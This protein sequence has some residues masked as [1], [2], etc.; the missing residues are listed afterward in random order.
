M[1]KDVFWLTIFFLFFG[2]GKPTPLLAKDTEVFAS[3]PYPPNIM[4][5]LDNSISMGNVSGYSVFDLDK[6][7]RANEANRYP[8]NH[9]NYLHKAGVGF[10]MIAA[11][12]AYENCKLKKTPDECQKTNMPGIPYY[13]GPSE[14]AHSTEPVPGSDP[15]N[16]IQWYNPDNPRFS[17]N[18]YGNPPVVAHYS[19]GI[20][21]PFDDNPIHYPDMDGDGDKDDDDLAFFPYYDNPNDFMLKGAGIGPYADKLLELVALQNQL[22]AEGR[23]AEYIAEKTKEWLEAIQL[24]GSYNEIAGLF[25]FSI[26]RAFGV[27][28][29]SKEACQLDLARDPLGTFTYGVMGMILNWFI[30][31]SPSE[32]E[33]ITFANP[34]PINHPVP[35]F[36]PPAHQ[37]NGTTNN[38]NNGGGTFPEGEGRFDRD[39]DCSYARGPI[40]SFV[41]PNP[42][43]HSPI[44]DQLTAFFVPDPTAP[45]KLEDVKDAIGTFFGTQGV[46][47][48][49]WGLMSYNNISYRY[50]QSDVT[51]SCDLLDGCLCGGGSLHSKY[52]PEGDPS[53]NSPVLDFYSSFRPAFSGLP[54]C[55][56][57]RGGESAVG[58]KILQKIDD[59][60]IA[61]IQAELDLIRPNVRGTPLA[62]TLLTAYLYFNETL[63]MKDE[64]VDLPSPPPGYPS[65]WYDGWWSPTNP[66]GDGGTVG[67]QKGGCPDGAD[68][69]SGAPN[70]CYDFCNGGCDENG[71]CINEP[72]G[73]ICDSCQRNYIILLTDGMPDRDGDGMQS[74]YQEL[75]VSWGERE[76]MNDFDWLLPGPC[77]Q[78]DGNNLEDC[79]LTNESDLVDEGFD[80]MFY[81]DFGTSDGDSDRCIG[82]LNPE[83]GVEG[84]LSVFHPDL[85]LQVKLDGGFNHAA[86]EICDHREFD[87]SYPIQV[88]LYGSSLLDDFAKFINEEDVLPDIE[89]ESETKGTQHIKTYTIGFDFLNKPYT[90]KNGL[91]SSYSA[92]GWYYPEWDEAWQLL[93]SA[94]EKGGTTEAYQ[95]TDNED[96]LDVMAAI[97][98]EILGTFSLSAPLVHT[99]RSSEAT[100]AEVTYIASF[101]RGAYLNV[102]QVL[103]ENPPMDP[104]HLQAWCTDYQGMIRVLSPDNATIEGCR[105]EIQRKPNCDYDDPC[106]ALTKVKTVGSSINPI[107]VS[108]TYVLEPSGYLWDAAEE[109]K[110]DKKSPDSR[111]IYTSKPDDYGNL[112]LLEFNYFNI[113]REDVGCWQRNNWWRQWQCPPDWTGW[114]IW[115]HVEASK[116][117]KNKL[118][119]YVR[120]NFYDGKGINFPDWT[121]VD[122]VEYPERPGKERLGSIIHSNMVHVGAPSRLYKEEG[123]NYA[124]EGDN[125]T[126]YF[127]FQYGL[128][129]PT[130]GENTRNRI[131]VVGANDGML[132]GFLAGKWE[133]DDTDKAWKY[134]AGTGEEIW[135][136]IPNTI[137]KKLPEIW[138]SGG[139]FV[140]GPISVVD[141]WADGYNHRTGTFS[142]GRDNK[143]QW[144]EWATVL[145]A[146]LG[147]NGNNS[148]YYAYVALDITQGDD[149][150]NPNIHALWEFTDD[151]LGAARSKPTV[152]KVRTE[153]NGSLQDQWVVFFG[154]G[155][156]EN[157]RGNALF[158]LDLFT[159]EEV[160]R[161]TDDPNLDN[162]GTRDPLNHRE[163][164]GDIVSEPL[165]ASLDSWQ[166][167]GPDSELV[168]WDDTLYVGDLKGNFWKFD[169]SSPDPNNW[170]GRIMMRPSGT[171]SSG[172]PDYSAS[173]D[174]PFFYPPA[175]AWDSSG[176]AWLAIGSG[177]R[178]DLREIPA[179]PDGFFA[180]RDEHLLL[181]SQ[182]NGGKGSKTLNARNSDNPGIP[183][184]L[185][186]VDYRNTNN[187]PGDRS[188]KG[189]FLSFTDSGSDS[190]SPFG[191]KVLDKARV[192]GG[193][194][195]YTTYTPPLLG[196]D[197]ENLAYGFAELWEMNLSTGDP[198]FDMNNDK[199]IDASDR[200]L[201]I[202]TG[203][204][205]APAVSAGELTPENRGGIKIVTQSSGTGSGM[206]IS[207][208][209]V[210]GGAMNS[211]SFNF[212]TTKV[213]IDAWAEW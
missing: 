81:R 136:Y 125:E 29:F 205:S 167:P 6:A 178:D 93:N 190:G 56:D 10:Q 196:E 213:A 5:I 40:Y 154:G 38:P 58:G 43:S 133:Q 3:D 168:L 211:G 141:A 157:G 49:R 89:E 27:V 4:L 101:D 132:H 199:A 72:E 160:W 77:N 176:R 100:A 13:S 55:W 209:D 122:P 185:F 62:E 8:S 53:G 106:S 67:Y 128:Q 98:D 207:V 47:Q 25:I 95:A 66:W 34:W 108:N 198:G 150:S 113:E 60:N 115:T 61:N 91:E 1:K 42:D 107:N 159:G 87:V 50:F 129:D 120:G 138:R 112:Q 130:S 202:G 85:G 22:Q 82:R 203:I 109:L 65:K 52:T 31:A 201:I 148:D 23:D 170:R 88:N 172:L 84:Y 17:L 102:P 24:S 192:V 166:Q 151:Y 116:R 99:F 73:P 110:P 96:L 135:A 71:N 80:Y 174:Q 12:A 9:I 86:V 163:Y 164:L 124:P 37:Y 117:F 158:A 131:V 193:I 200:S 137:L 171:A 35:P 74:P 187:A 143:K 152:A 64:T 156:A 75:D 139:T 69:F 79:P 41:D 30:E 48:L 18:T 121:W 20:G 46:D 68:C 15:V 119:D 63:D 155:L 191:K 181:E 26:V 123:Y 39:L 44:L 32:N 186:P 78:R 146:G 210:P 140:D 7:E 144:T 175:M 212:L 83:T 183:A 92:L 76:F 145:I 54:C 189:W 21:R 126:N 161:F 149:P 188:W 97:L 177:N 127:L 19:G 179:K 182:W 114:N 118:I 169:I 33:N 2:L 142:G 59:E 11:Q 173:V 90:D 104:G 165:L 197:C 45:S 194:V 206:N 70:D 184:D 57:F 147:D 103:G 16:L 134:D 105:A 14:A 195:F 180:F 111:N 28:M 36:W 204:A 208:V 162:A 153:K 94:A 51:C